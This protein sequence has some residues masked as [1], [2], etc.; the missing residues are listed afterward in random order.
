M[1]IDAYAHVFPMRLIDALSEVSGS[2]ELAALRAQSPH[3]YDDERRIQF[4]DERGLDIQVLV[5]ARPPVWLGMKREVIH[6]LTRVANDSIAEF[7]RRRSDRFIGVGV[8]PVV[9][10]VMM[11]EFERLRGELGLKGVLIFS[12]IE[13]R[14]LDD[15]SMW[16]LYERAAAADVPIWIHPQHADYY[17][18]IG[19]NVL[20]RTLGWPFD[21]SLAMARLVY[22]GVFEKYPGIKFV[23]HHMGGMIPYFAKR[24]E[25]FERSTAAEYA[26]LGIGGSAGPAL[27]GPGIDHFRRFYND[28]ISNGSV[29]ALTLAIR[30]FG[31]DHILFGTDFPF[32][33]QDGSWVLD[34]LRA[35]ATVDIEPEQREQI[36]H[37]NAE[38]LL[39]LG[40]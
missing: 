34:E 37:G 38:K 12:N 31:V 28:C 25:A 10:D 4:M 30:F 27:T 23:T 39:G 1:V 15:P 33:P 36:L 5:L 24:I 3:L 9:D 26:R 8:L 19:K 13:G 7:A 16:P 21:T 14:A 2:A 22:G 18:W 40:S 6:R 20:D 35:V 29:E 17:P 32:G 11:Q